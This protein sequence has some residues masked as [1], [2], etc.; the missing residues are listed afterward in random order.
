VPKFIVSNR[1]SKFI[2]KFWQS[3]YNTLDTKLSLSAAFHLQ[4]DSQLEGIIEILKDMLHA[5]V[6]SWK[7][8]WK[9]HLPW[10]R[11]DYNNYHAS[12]NMALYES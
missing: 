7:D 11:F 5:S 6:L 1:D 8:S 3:L 2:S 12:I 4:T 10:T 9:D